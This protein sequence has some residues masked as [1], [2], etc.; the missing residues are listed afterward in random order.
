MNI[1]ES[2]VIVK[3]ILQVVFAGLV[4]FIIS[5]FASAEELTGNWIAKEI[6]FHGVNIPI[7]SVS[8]SD[9]TKSSFSLSLEILEG[10]NC[11]LIFKNVSYPASVCT[12]S[13]NNSVKVG[14]NKYNLKMNKDG[15]IFLSLNK[16]LLIR[17]EKSE[18]SPEKRELLKIEN[19]L[20]EEKR[21]EALRR[22]EEE[23]EAAILAAI[24]PESVYNM[25][26][27]F[28]DED[29]QKMSA[30]MLYGRYY[31]DGNTMIGMA[32]DKSGTLP[33]LVKSTISL[34]DNTPT[35]EAFT[36]LDRH[37]NANFL[38]PDL[39]Q[40]YYIR[41][42]RD[43][44]LSSLARLD[45][46]T[47]RITRIGT[48]MHEMAY[49]QI[50]DGRLWYTGEEHRL[51]SCKKNGK[52]NQIEL[53]KAVYDPYFLTEDWMIYQDDADGETLHLW[54]IKDGTDLKI[55]ETRSFNPIV[56]GT[57]LYFTS[58]PDDGGKA[59][60]SRADLSKPIKEG[61]LCYNIEKSELPMSKSFYI[62]GSTIYG[63]NNSSIDIDNWKKLTNKAWL[64]I[65]QRYFYI[66]DP[67]I[68][69]GE[70]YS[71]HATV[72]SLYLLEKK[73]GLISIFRHVY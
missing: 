63:E 23:A 28:S 55:T 66:G 1:T 65:T 37:V 21:E 59:Y 60:L 3:R 45:M 14:T 34:K 39:N 62:F 22:A 15:S 67:Y 71:E 35:Q 68:V 17:F 20:E 26:V 2:R 51:Y 6:N 32:Y 73:S 11:S 38:T 29:T 49:L 69:Y 44:G 72:T 61:D 19:L 53:D 57:M 50:H 25:C 12:D 56:D 43:T 8:D 18:N 7:E 31:F 40:L 10:E 4:L 27:S 70:M 24:K 58:I 16:E 36:V 9:S 30:F 33:N 5:S 47:E 42:D 13:N 64:T 48:E 41:V 52:D 54:C 46:K